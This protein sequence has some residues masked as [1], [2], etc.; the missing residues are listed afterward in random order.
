MSNPISSIFRPMPFVGSQLSVSF[1]STPPSTGKSLHERIVSQLDQCETKLDQLMRNHL[2]QSKIDSF[3]QQI[4]NAFNF[5][6]LQPFNDWINDTGNEAWYTQLAIFL[7]KLPLKAARNILHTL[8]TLIKNTLKATIY[9]VTHP[10]KA[11]LELAKWLTT[12]I[13]E[14]S[15]PEVWT[16]IGI[17]MMGSNIGYTT[18]TGHPISSLLMAISGVMTIAGITMATLKAAIKAKRGHKLE[19]VRS[20][21]MYQT[22]MIAEEMT[23]GLL[24]GFII[25]GIQQMTRSIRQLKQ[26]MNYNEKVYNTRSALA[27]KQ[28]SEFTKE[29]NLPDWDRLAHTDHSFEILWKAEKDLFIKFLRSVPG[30]EFIMKEIITD[31]I[32]TRQFSHYATYPI[33]NGGFVR[34]PVYVTHYIPIHTL[35]IG[36]ELPLV[37]WTPPPAP[38]AVTMSNMTNKVS[39]F[40]QAFQRALVARNDGSA[41]II[42]EKK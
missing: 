40:P 30:T 29:Y 32:S 11:P 14:L 7:A 31:Y 6:S 36:Y 10:L 16:K 1:N 18:I 15:K 3:L 13:D 22:Q 5:P 17:N 2:I 27:S 34:Q 35:H 39:L 24:L 20:S 8:T 28:G 23:T 25:G 42:D 21:L 33:P 41:K 9:S 26:D 37:G 19:D 4:E 12:L 38:P